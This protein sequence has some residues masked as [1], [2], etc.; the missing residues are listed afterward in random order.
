MI[1]IGTFPHSLLT[2][3]SLSLSLSLSLSISLCAV[4]KWL[5]AHDPP[6]P[7]NYRVS[8]G[9]IAAASK[10]SGAGQML[11][12]VDSQEKSK[13]YRPEENEY[14]VWLRQ[15]AKNLPMPLIEEM[16]DWLVSEGAPEAARMAS[17][18]DT[19]PSPSPSPSSLACET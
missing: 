4:A 14:G 10:A 12:G 2:P 5:R 3:F 6:A 1:L 16:A 19:L 9:V 18:S 8:D 7:W 13:L 11:T 15:T 17:V